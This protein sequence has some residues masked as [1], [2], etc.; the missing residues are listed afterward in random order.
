[1]V[2]VHIPPHEF[3]EFFWHHLKRDIEQLG[4]ATG[5][6]VDESVIALH[7]VLKQILIQDPPT[8]KPRLLLCLAQT[9]IC[10]GDPSMKN[11]S[12]KIC[13]DVRAFLKRAYHVNLAKPFLQIVKS[14]VCSLISFSLLHSH[15]RVQAKD[16]GQGYVVCLCAYCTNV[17][18]H[19]Y[20]D[21]L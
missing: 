5:K 15:I 13:G 4:R 2:E 12:P 19:H 6:S 7:L 10:L 17:C 21:A 3:P 14:T 8:C 16:W 1:M 20:Y 9:L 18:K 11:A